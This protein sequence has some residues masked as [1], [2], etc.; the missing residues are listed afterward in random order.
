MCLIFG[1]LLCL[2]GEHTVAISSQRCQRMGCSDG[3]QAVRGGAVRKTERL[4]DMV[5]EAG[6]CGE[7]MTL[8]VRIS[9]CL[10]LQAAFVDLHS[11]LPYQHML[12]ALWPIVTAQVPCPAMCSSNSMQ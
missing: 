6:Q 9:L 3:L 5:S 10:L 8:Q 1:P 12:T 2:A 4:R 7:L 11:W